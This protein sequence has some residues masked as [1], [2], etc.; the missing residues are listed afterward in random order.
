VFELVGEAIGFLAEQIRGVIS[1]ITG[2]ND[3]AREGGSVWNDLGTV[4]GAVAGVVG[5]ILAAAIGAVAL[6]LET[7]VEIVRAV[8]HIFSELGRFIG[9]TAAKIYLFFTETIPQAFQSVAGAVRSF[10]QPV[11]DFV[12]GIVDGL[13]HALERILSFTGRLVAKIPARFRPAFL[14]SI[15]DASEAAEASLAARTTRATGPAIAAL[16]PTV[17]AAAL[18]NSAAGLPGGPLVP[19]VAGAIPAAAELT[20]RGQISDAELDAI[21]ARGVAVADLRPI[22][23]HVTLHVDGETL[24]RATARAD[25]SNAA[26]AFVPLPVGR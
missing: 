15:V 26:R 19:A 8:I 21:V 12:T 4:L 10:F 3:R 2:V 25:R 16:A 20:A 7:V 23:T 14:D 22:Q 1:D 18:T 24:A 6:A 13:E 17:A 9:E 11:L 5:G